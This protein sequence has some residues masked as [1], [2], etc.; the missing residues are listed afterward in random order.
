MKNFLL[1]EAPSATEPVTPSPDPDPVM[2]RNTSAPLTTS[3]G[4][5]TVT[6]ISALSVV[7]EQLES[8]LLGK[9]AQ[10][11]LAVACL[12]ARG[13]LLIEDVPG[14]GK[15]TLAQALGKSL[16][17]PWT[18]VQFTSDL[19]PAD[20]LGVSIFN[21]QTQEFEFKPGPVFTSVLLADEINRAPAKAQSA[22]LEAMEERQVSIDG[23]THDLPADFFVIA[24][25]NP[26]DQLGAYPLP[27]SQLDRFLVGIEIGYP[28]TNSERQLLEHG[29]R[30]SSIE[31]LP[32]IANPLQLK[33]W[34]Q[35]CEVVTAAPT[36]LDYVQALLLET[37][38]SG[39]GLSPRA[40]LSLVRLCRS[41]ALLQGRTHV[42]P[43][44]VRAVFPALAGHRLT[45]HVKSGRTA[46]LDVLQRVPMP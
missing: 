32:A 16:G 38:E 37:R 1:R 29:D 22:L 35:D 30:R 5:T 11:E 10:L 17:L 34:M 25:Q 39:N 27:E 31:A 26:T 12:L 18:R 46:A 13:H 28:D 33:Q 9:R 42:L 6:A 21:N 20:V 4:N 36:I 45:G 2:P 19:L 43:D 3:K 41:F 23:I 7:L 15:T 44:D 40:G 14:V 24:T 8:V